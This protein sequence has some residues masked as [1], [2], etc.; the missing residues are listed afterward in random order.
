MKY[1][2]EH[3]ADV[4]HKHVYSDIPFHKTSEPALLDIGK[5]S[6]EHGGHSNHINHYRDIPLHKGFQTGSLEIMK[7]LIEHGADVNYE[8]FF[9]DIP[10][11]TAV[12]PDVNCKH[13][14]GDTPLHTAVKLGLLEIVKYLIEPGADINCEIDGEGAPIDVAAETMSLKMVEYLFENNGKVTRNDD[15]TWSNILYLACQKGKTLVVEHLLQNNV[16][17]EITKYFDALVS[18]LRI[19]CY[20]GHTAVVQTLLKYNANIRNEKKLE[21]A[22]EEIISIL[23]IEM[24]KSIKHQKKIQILKQMRKEMLVKVRLCKFL[25]VCLN[26]SSSKFRVLQEL[27]HVQTN[28][29]NIT[30]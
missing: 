3:G 30:S 14:D 10:L 9:R 6:F 18:P 16:I 25:S 8:N 7:Y 1:L 29:E 26:C 4:N 19:A 28:S 11:Q 15:D 5:Y 12:E 22:N 2:V 13:I 24:R 17:K 21:C 27:R 23:N 20:Y